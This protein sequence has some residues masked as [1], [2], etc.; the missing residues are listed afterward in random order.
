MK[1]G[2]VVASLA[3]LTVVLIISAATAL[4]GFFCITWGLAFTGFMMGQADAVNAAMMT[5]GILALIV[6]L[7]AMSL[8]GIS[9]YV[10]VA[11]RQWPVAGAAAISICV[12]GAASVA[13]QA[14]AL[15]VSFIVAGQLKTP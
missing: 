15:L 2:I 8:S 6:T 11:K 9:V 10:L 1:A 4:L 14:L 13:G 7:V 12:A 5:F 3:S